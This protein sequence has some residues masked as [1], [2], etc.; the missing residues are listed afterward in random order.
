M[1][2][3][4]TAED[5]RRIE[6]GKMAEELVHRLVRAWVPSM[7]TASANDLSQDTNVA[8]MIRDLRDREG[9]PIPLVLPDFDLAG[10]GLRAWLEVKARARCGDFDPDSAARTNV[11]K[12][13]GLVR[14]PLW[15]HYVQIQAETG[16]PVFLAIYEDDQGDILIAS[17]DELNVPY[18]DG[19]MSECVGSLAGHLTFLR[20]SLEVWGWKDPGSGEWEPQQED[21]WLEDRIRE[22]YRRHW[23]SIQ[24]E[25]AMTR[26]TGHDPFNG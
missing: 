13:T 3:A 20:D 23:A 12:T 2:Q 4:K 26:A 8:P 19:P 10:K 1:I 24:G 15:Q 17:L 18:P 21:G 6:F 16:T 14:I 11:K 7:G 22:W 25:G 9:N 5:R